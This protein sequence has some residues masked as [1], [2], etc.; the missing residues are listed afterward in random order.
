MHRVATAIYGQTPHSA[1]QRMGHGAWGMGHG[2]P[3]DAQG[4]ACMV[5]FWRLS[6]ESKTAYENKHACTECLVDVDMVIHAC[7][8]ACM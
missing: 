1:A 2:V 4:T 8:H 3:S 6:D 5:R 7:M